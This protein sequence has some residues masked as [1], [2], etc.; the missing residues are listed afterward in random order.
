MIVGNIKD[1]QGNPINHPSALNASMK[2]LVSKEEGWDDY[3]MREL[4]VEVN[5]YTPKHSHPW[6]HINYMISGKGELLLGD[7]T[8]KVEAGGF[9]FVPSNI[10]HQFRNIGDEPFEFICIVPKEGHK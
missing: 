8:H 2:V 7:E 9:A 3:V 10:L 1:V 5:G 4:V 6:P